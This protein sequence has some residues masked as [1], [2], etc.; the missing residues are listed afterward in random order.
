MKIV[1]FNDTST[2]EHIGCQAVSNS[3]KRGLKRHEIIH[4]YPVS[5]FISLSKLDEK[6][7]LKSLRTN[8]NLISYIE[9][10]DGIVI[11]GEGT[12]HHD[13]GSEYLAI[14]KI[15][16]EHN[17]KVFLVNTI[18][19]EMSKHVDVLKLIDD[20]AVREMFSK[21]EVE[22]LGGKARLVLDSILDAQFQPVD[23]VDF[24]NTVVFTDYH[25]ERQRDV[26]KAMEEAYI[27]LPKAYGGR[28]VSFYPM[29][30]KN[31]KSV[32]K[33]AVQNLRTANTVI[34]GRHHGVY[35]AG[36]AGVPFVACG[37]NSWKIESLIKTSG[38]P[39]PVCNDSQEMYYAYQLAQNSPELFREFSSF[40][41]ENSIAKG[42]LE[43]FSVMN[44]IDN[45]ATS[46]D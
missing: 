33:H 34:T 14:A 11:N 45:D 12:L 17:K 38:L 8:K 36:L 40:L 1:L 28:G 41:Y 19:Q 23:C 32:W 42:G 39:I 27:N 46:S 25:H 37:G 22:K 15:A 43:T 6:S 21:S 7:Q 29:H 4:S 9:K 31:A 24:A 35:L 2:I 16:K 30:V 10:S 13:R 26:G 5:S 18:F 3:H 20:I 44:A